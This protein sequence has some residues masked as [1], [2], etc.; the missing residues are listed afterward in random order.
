MLLTVACHHS[1]G[2]CSD[3]N[4]RGVDRVC[5]DDAVPRTLPCSSISSALLPVVETSI[6][7]KTVICKILFGWS[8]SMNFHRA[9]EHALFDI[10]QLCAGHFELTQQADIVRGTADHDAKF[11]GFDG[12][13][14][15]LV[16]ISQHIH[17]QMGGD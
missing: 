13:P 9:D 6:P 4:G 11:T 8:R 1:S 17:R 14:Q 15:V 16:I 2:S 10:D 3:H 5:G 12:Q 7:M